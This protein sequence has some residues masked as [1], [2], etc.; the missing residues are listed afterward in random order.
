MLKETFFAL[1][2]AYTGDTSLT[3]DLWT[4]IERNYSKSAR[5]YHTLRHLESLLNELQEIKH[6][7]ND[8]N[9]ILFTLFYHDII[10]NTL[11]SNNEEKSAALAEKRL[12]A[13]SVPQQA[14]DLCTHQVLAT[15]QHQLNPDSDTNYFTDA[16]LSILGRHWETYEKYAANVRKEYAIYPDLIYNPGRTKVLRSF[17][18]MERIFKMDHFFKKYETAAR[19]NLQK[20]IEQLL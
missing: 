13:L 1:A 19:H 9:T 6:L 10:Y 3:N 5:H 14:I 8:W 20:E 12:R 15:K 17:L 7:I 11:K 18:A 4:E 2:K 16:D